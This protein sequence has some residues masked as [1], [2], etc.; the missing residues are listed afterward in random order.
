LLPEMEVDMAA[1][2]VFCH[3]A[4]VFMKRVCKRGVRCFFIGRSKRQTRSHTPSNSKIFE[5]SLPIFYYRLTCAPK[6]HPIF[7]C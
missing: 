2:G 1:S 3:S 4:C 6:P 7:Q 5:I